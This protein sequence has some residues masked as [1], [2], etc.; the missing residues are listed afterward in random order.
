MKSTII[1]ISWPIKP[2]MTTYKNN[3]PVTF[4]PLKN[5]P[6]DD[7][8]DSL[9]ALNVHTGTHV[10]APSHFLEEGSSIEG[11]S[12]DQL[13]GKAVVIDLTNVEEKI[14][15]KNLQAYSLTKNDIVLLKTKNSL[16]NADESFDF[17]FIY[18][19]P[20][21]ASFLAQ[22]GVKAV[23]IDYLGI[24]RNSPNHETHSILLEQQIPII[25]GLRL[26][27]VAAGSYQFCCLPIA[28]EGLEAA[29]ARA[30]LIA[31]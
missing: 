8:R 10:D 13:I 27:H 22:Q 30:I 28:I 14:T 23:G 21:A 15:A 26:D 20:C 18:L 11:F 29:P 31:P 6:Q 9:I 7:V 12:L 1:D 5:F 24:E 4:T 25:E 19:A 2:S 3:K 17:N 16:R